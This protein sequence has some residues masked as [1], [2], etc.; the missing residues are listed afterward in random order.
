MPSKKKKNSVIAICIQEPQED[1]STMDLGAIQGDDLR[2]LHQ[3]FITDTIVNALQVSP[4]DSR[5]YYIDDLERTRLVKIVSEYLGK[6]LTGSPLEA[7]KKR[8]TAH[9]M[10]RERWGLRIEKIFQDCFDAGY[11]NV[12][13][14]GSRTPTVTPKMMR[15]ALRMLEQSDAVFGP[16]PDGR[17]YTIGM[18]GE[19]RIKLS[20]FDW[21]SPSI[22]SEVANAFTEQDLSWSELEIWYAIEGSE[23][24]DLLA[25]DIN[26]YRFEEDELTARETEAV[27]ERLIARL[28]S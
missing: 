23:E 13:V 10:D 15:T 20:N 17:Y 9:P 3:A 4:A 27:M 22:Y 11:R 16:T 14:I 8:F 5:L 7:F 21:K 28:G 25:R 26:Q 1:G 19:Y 2:F 18:S 12:L 6:K 24:L